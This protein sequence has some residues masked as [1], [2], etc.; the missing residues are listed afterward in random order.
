VLQVPSADVKGIKATPFWRVWTADAEASLNDLRALSHYRFDADRYRSLN[1]PVQLLIGS[2][3]P[4][5]IYLT[6]ALAAVLPDVRIVALDGQAHEGMT[7]APKRF[8]EAIARFL[9]E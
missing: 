9:L 6:D 3:S 8:V 4:G 7:I 1:R 2:E 5:E